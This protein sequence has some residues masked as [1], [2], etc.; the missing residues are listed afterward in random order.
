MQWRARFRHDGAQKFI[1]MPEPLNQ[2]T[3]RRFRKLVDQSPLHFLDLR[4]VPIR[5][6]RCLHNRITQEFLSSVVQCRLGLR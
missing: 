3:I 1:D 2:M 5:R 4:P 6:F